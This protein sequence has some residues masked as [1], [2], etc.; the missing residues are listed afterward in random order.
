M[1]FLACLTK[2]TTS[3]LKRRLQK[4]VSTRALHNKVL[5]FSVG[6]ASDWDRNSDEVKQL[7]KIFADWLLGNPQLHD[8]L[9][10]IDECA[11][12]LWTNHRRVWHFKGVPRRIRRTHSRSP[13]IHMAGASSPTFGCV[14]AATSR[15]HY[16]AE[17]FLAFLDE[18]LNKMN[19]AIA[20]YCGST[21]HPIPRMPVVTLI[22]DNSSVHLKDLIAARLQRENMKLASM[23]RALPH[24]AALPDEYAVKFL[25]PKSPMLNVIEEVWSEYKTHVRRAI[26]KVLPQ[27]I[28]LDQVQARR[29]KGNSKGEERAKILERI[30]QQSWACIPKEHH[31]S[32]FRHCL[33]DAAKAQQLE[34]V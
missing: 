5:V 23:D 31:A 21:T 4:L 33:Q 30:A 14:Y 10:F 20:F 15:N 34:D 19:D 11:I 24:H 26:P 18:L 28:A 9:L 7:R 13:A 12:D 1:S 2:T 8:G 29:S 6:Q 32:H 25:P 16:N 27:L 3:V 17:T 22:M